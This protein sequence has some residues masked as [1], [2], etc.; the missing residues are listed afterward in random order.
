MQSERT[1]RVDAAEQTLIAAML[2]GDEAAFRTFFDS[3]F[4]RVYRF[5]LPRVG[6]DPEAAKEVAQSTLIKAMRNLARFRGEAALFSWL[7]QICRRQVVD[8]LRMH[9]RHVDHVDTIDASEQLQTTIESIAAPA[10]DEPPHRYN[11]SQTRQLVQSVLDS[12]P[13][14]YSDVLQ[15]KYLEDRSVVEIGDSLGIG[16][17]AAQSILARA[18]TAFREALEAVFGAAARDILAS[19]H[20][21]TAETLSRNAALPLR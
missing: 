1:H 12:L 2:D 3:H 14:R 8:Y 21:T 13:S 9:K 16:H 20:G 15:W 5:A 18:R 17:S 19:M 10:T 7:C 4:S 11:A 6:G